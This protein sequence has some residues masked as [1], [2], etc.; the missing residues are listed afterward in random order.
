MKSL[1]DE[2]PPEFAALVHPEWRKNEAA[3][4]AMRD[5]IVKDYGGQWVAYSDGAVIAHGPSPV[6]VL[7]AGVGPGRHPF[8]T[9]LGHEDQPT[10]I[11]RASFAYDAGYPI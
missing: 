9:C 4:W 6:D 10:P 7:H 5:A 11:R 3:Y 1:A 2:L 8:V